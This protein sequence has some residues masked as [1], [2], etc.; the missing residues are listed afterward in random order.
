MSERKDIPEQQNISD[1][2]EMLK[3]S[4]SADSAQTVSETIDNDAHGSES[5]SDEE[6]K[7]KL[8]MQFM[9]ENAAEPPKPE[10][11]SYS[12][13]EDFFAEAEPESEE[14]V[15]EEAVEEE[16]GEELESDTLE[17]INFAEDELPEEEQYIDN[18]AQEESDVELP[19]DDDLV[20]GTDDGYFDLSSVLEEKENR[21]GISEAA[22]ALEREI[23][24]TDDVDDAEELITDED[25]DLTFDQLEDVEDDSGIVF[26]K[27]DVE[28]SDEDIT[29][30]ELDD[31]AEDDGVVYTKLEINE[32]PVDEEL[33]E[34]VLENIEDS[35]DGISVM[36]LE[37]ETLD[38]EDV[39][40]LRAEVEDRVEENAADDMPHES[41]KA[42]ISNTSFASTTSEQ[43]VETVEAEAEISPEEP[44]YQEQDESVDGD[45]LDELIF[46]SSTEAKNS[47]EKIDVDR[48]EISL[49]MQLGCD[50]EILER[51]D[52]T[53][54][55]R[56][57][58]A[59]AFEDV[60][61]EEN[62]FSKDKEAKASGD[63]AKE[64][65][66]ALYE[67]YRSRRG[68]LLLKLGLS[69]VIAFVLLL[70]EGLPIIGV[71]LPGILNREEYYISYVFM[72][73]QGLV[74]CGLICYKRIW[75]GATRLLT[76]SPNVYSVITL[77]AGMTLL[78]DFSA[79]FAKDTVP[80]TFHF[81]TVL[82]IALALLMDCQDLSAERRSFEFFFS[83]TLYAEYNSEEHEMERFTL[84]KSQGKSSTAEKMYSG[85]LDPS[86]NV[87]FPISIDN[88]AGFFKTQGNR[89]RKNNAPMWQIM[90]SLVISLLVGIFAFI[91]GGEVWMGFGGMLL[92]MLLSMPLVATV[93]MWLPFNR[94]STKSMEDGYSFANETSMEGYSDCDVAVFSDLHLFERC[95]PSR[96][97]LALYDATAKDILLGCLGAVYSEIGGPMSETFVASAKSI[98]KCRLTRVA[99]SGIEAIVGSNYSVLLG[100]EAFMQRYGI[101]FPKVALND[102]HDRVF[103][104]CVS[105]NGRATARIA[106]RYTVSRVF[107]MLTDR[108]EQD[109]I[110]CAVETLD[111][112][113]S[114]ELLARVRGEDS[115]PI[116]IVHLNAS[117]YVARRDKDREKKL[118]NA[119]G[120]ALGIIADGS[121][122]N[123]AV[124][125]SAAKRMRKLRR[126]LNIISFA[127]SG[128]GA[129]IAFAAAGF[130]WIAGFSEFFV[131]LYW[132]ACAALLVT[133]TLRG[134]PKNDRFS[135]EQ[136]E[137]E[138][139]ERNKE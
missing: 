69:L 55:E 22:Q 64:K 13:D 75:D 77:L 86:Q 82:A 135:L 88:A 111:P 122:L 92:S 93:A 83:D 94:I 101:S 108:L 78:Y 71:E 100:N 59:E 66:L 29:F 15:M 36:H 67:G 91:A 89:S 24:N 104:L 74:L 112:M 35:E 5:M 53:T 115:A 72:G 73:L 2:L 21:D 52:S 107:E 60:D 119:S 106:V 109:G 103:T 34:N 4:Y 46:D 56:V 42:L 25:S 8:R 58:K 26:T 32:D 70:Y 136:Y 3:Q 17:E 16:V 138:L 105:I 68:S 41:F 14:T 43:C 87:Y 120:E 121:R 31:S 63:E 124:A 116:S 80:P 79:L 132:L 126:I 1:V 44:L 113:I 48:S 99:K 23:L 129:L 12:I 134:V 9:A 123:L 127:C 45:F 39:A 114:T 130:G 76:K 20:E 51:Y 11:D 90:P 137:Y 37:L 128:V 65:I 10:Y 95:A 110:Y 7:A 54:I 18:V 38:E 139:E 61:V 96:V 62:D 19:W 57:S 98:G 49:L 118:F 97:N 28:G 125:L 50:D 81:V 85:G 40:E 47:K 33:D 30:D 133:V 84:C 131:L 117:D 27:L 102:E 6:L